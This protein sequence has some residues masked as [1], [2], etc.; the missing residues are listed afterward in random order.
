MVNQ[1]DFLASLL[2]DGSRASQQWEAQFEQWAQAPSAGERERAENAIRAIRNAIDRSPELAKRDIK[3]FVQGS[4]R[5]RVNVRKESDV[6]VGVLLYSDIFYADYPAGKSREDFGFGPATYDYEQ[7]KNEIERALVSYFGREFVRRGKKAFDVRAS[8]YKFDADVVPL[9][10]FRQYWEDGTFRAGCALFP[11][12]G[13]RIENYPERLLDHWPQI[14]QHYENG[15]SKNDRTGRRFKSV[16]RILKSL[17]NEMADKGTAAASSV[18]GYLLECLAWNVPDDR[19]GNSTWVQELRTALAYLSSHLGD[20]TK[21]SEWTEVDGIKYLFH[22]NQ[23]WTRQ[24][25]YEFVR[26]AIKHL[27]FGG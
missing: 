9:A 4:Y 5:N 16:V 26:A 11:E 21:C 10:E 17:R 6:D 22:A 19:Y 3:V 8:S 15:V 25:A 24:Q 12:G 2:S 14:P 20:S 27:G 23:P 18:P 7:F 13:H 1:S